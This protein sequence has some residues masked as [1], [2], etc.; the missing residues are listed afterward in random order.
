MSRGP[1]DCV[2]AVRQGARDL[3]D[4]DAR[5]LVST[6]GAELRTTRIALGKSQSLVARAAGVTPSALGRLERGAV[7]GPSLVKV[8]R[9]ARALG[10][11]ASMRLYPAGS[12]VRDAAQL[13]VLDRVD[14]ILGKPLRSRREVLLPADEEL[15]AWDA[16]ISD[17]DGVAFVDAESRIGDVQ[18]LSRRLERKMRDDPR[19]SI[20]ILA[21][22][23]TRHNSAVLAEHR[24]RV[25]SLLPLDGAAILRALRAG[26]LPAASGIVVI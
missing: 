10:L 23:R 18:E 17:E 22:A 21:V 4:A 11:A 3:G 20:L 15:R 26:R 16:A 1:H 24:E 8:C 2:M 12:P 13:G 5:R 25:R 6:T 14:A 7:K 19:S 9:V